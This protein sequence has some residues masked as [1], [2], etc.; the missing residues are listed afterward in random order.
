MLGSISDW[1]IVIVVAVILFGGASKIPELFRNL[2]RAMG[3]L[4]R[5]QMEVQK[6]LERELQANQN[7]LSQTQNQAKAE[8][9]QR[10]IQELQAELDRLK[11]NSVVKEKD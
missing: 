11:G 4:K 9:L 3:E 1:A 6:E 5:G 2:G 10:K 8:E 7:Q